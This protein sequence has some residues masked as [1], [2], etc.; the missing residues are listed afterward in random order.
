MKA[1][2]VLPLVTATACSAATATVKVDPQ[3]GWDGSAEVLVHS[4]QGSLESR[5]PITSSLVVT[6]DDGDTVT[7]VVNSDGIT[8]LQSNLDIRDGDVIEVPLYPLGTGS[9][10]SITVDVPAVA[11]AT[12]WVVSTPYEFG[13]VSSPITIDVTPGQTSTPV[14]V[15]A[16]D[17]SAALALYGSASATIDTATASMDL[18]TTIPYQTVIIQPDTL[19]PGADASSLSPDGNF[20]ISGQE[21]QPAAVGSA[22]IEPVGIGEHFGVDDFVWIDS[23]D[24]N[25]TEDATAG[26]VTGT[27]PTGVVTVALSATAVPQPVALALGPALGGAQWEARRQRHELRLHLGHADRLDRFELPVVGDGA[28]GHDVLRVP[29]D[30][31]GPRPAHLRL[32]R[33]LD[34]RA[35]HARRLRRG[36]PHLDR[37]RRRHL[38]RPRHR[39]HAR[40]DDHTHGSRPPAGYAGSRSLE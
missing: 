17:G 10:T 32:A 27:L 14:F 16:T 38:A 21:L 20:F 15:T 31:G 6:L 28:A 33:G 8:Q 23:N 5:T 3:A 18:Q 1:W 11:S 25:T 24:A 30:A 29:G 22:L 36:A 2:S 9:S 7:V 26:S 40:D 34:G 37:A 19:P 4:P 35:E 12:T 13:E 39:A